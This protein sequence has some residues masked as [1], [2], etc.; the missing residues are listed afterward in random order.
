MN[1]I[2]ESLVDSKA[3]EE[4]KVTVLDVLLRHC[5]THSDMKREFSTQTESSG[6]TA[7]EALEESLQELRTSFR[8]SQQEAPSAATTIQERMVAFHRDCERR[9]QSDVAMQVA[10]IRETEMTRVRLEEAAKARAEMDAQR[11]RLELDYARRLQALVESEAALSRRMADQELG[12]QRT[13]YDARQQM[14]R[15]I[16]A[17]RGREAAAVRQQEL[18]GQGVRMLELRLK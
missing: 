8:A 18:E 11:K 12:A 4:G 2:D 15:E 7:R 6:Q 3:R 13:L 16:D 10:H 5:T 1:Q 9:V 14:Q 17:L